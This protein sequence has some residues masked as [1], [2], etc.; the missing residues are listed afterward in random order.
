MNTMK[1]NLADL[2]VIATTMP[3]GRYGARHIDR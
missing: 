3:L 2:T 1:Y